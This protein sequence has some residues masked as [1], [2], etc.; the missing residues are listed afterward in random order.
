MRLGSVLRGIGPPTFMVTLGMLP[1]FLV[2][3]LSVVMGPALGFTASLVGTAVGLN[4]L[5]A[6]F[7]TVRAG[8]RVQQWGAS[9]GFGA[10]AFGTGSALVLIAMSPTWVTVLVAMIL[11]GAG[12][13]FLQVAANLRIAEG[14]PPER[15]GLAYSVK[16]SSIPLATLLAGAAVPS[17]SGVLSWRW[18]FFGAALAVVVV[19]TLQKPAR[20]TPRAA[21]EANRSPVERRSALV[22]L[23]IGVGF[24]SASATALAAFLV[25]Y[26]V[27]SGAP[28]REAGLALSVC[29]I[30]AITGRVTAG[31]A[32]DR[33]H[34]DGLM[35]MVGQVLIGALAIVVMSAAEFLGVVFMIAMIAAFAA[36]WAWSG[37]FTD[38]VVRRMPHAAASA[39]G[40]TQFGVYLGAGA[41]PVLFGLLVAFA[42]YSP[43][44]VA[45]A[46]GFVL[47]AWLIWLG[48]GRISAP[49]TVPRGGTAHDST[50]L[51]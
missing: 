3:S 22:V 19:W 41:G 51:P 24:A 8:H 4:F 49:V 38:A 42:G 21:R 2:A 7:V 29:S 46:C 18:I 15:L 12:T 44:L 27:A 40:I 48:S 32:R 10:G 17:V 6:M 9:W 23:A 1:A 26:L 36:G 13:A 45:L 28:K 47:S 39:T 11:S 5:S 35:V 14:I 43:A 50:E 33:W 31:L 20:A 34:L 37:V 25:P 16:Q 30:A